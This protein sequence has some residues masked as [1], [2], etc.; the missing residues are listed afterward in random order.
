M[1]LAR[2][3]GLQSVD[4][5]SGEA[6]QQYLFYRGESLCLGLSPA[7]REHPICVDFAEQL[8]RRHRGKELLLKAVGGRRAGLRVVDATAGLGRD[9]LLLA[10]YG[11]EVSLCEREPVVAEMLAD[12]LRRGRGQ[13]EV[14]ELVARMTLIPGSALVHLQGLAAAER[15]DVVYLDP[16]FPE[17]GKSAQVKKEMRL[18]HTLV[19]PDE[20]DGALLDQALQSARYRVVVKR[21]AKAPALL[22]PKPQYAVLG[23]A[24]RFD[25]YPLKAF[26]KG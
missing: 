7:Q 24:V 21:G 22:G 26:S 20:D 23:K 10:S 19:G 6:D 8:R 15:P 25:I 16:M 5:F 2:R 12:G 3:L 13:S 18:F 4:S 17:S 9:S 11:A 14:G 1:S